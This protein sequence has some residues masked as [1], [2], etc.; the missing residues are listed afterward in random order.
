MET[1]DKIVAPTRTPEI[2]RLD[3]VAKAIGL[4]GVALFESLK[5]AS[6]EARLDDTKAFPNN[7]EVHTEAIKENVAFTD[8]ALMIRL[9][10]AQVEEVI[11]NNSFNPVDLRHSLTPAIDRRKKENH[12]IAN[13]RKSL[14]GIRQNKPG[15]SFNIGRAK[16]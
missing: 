8:N 1:R 6:R 13:G 11:A 15:T 16:I 14:A 12:Q 3:R 4:G 10:T 2:S 7:A 9:Y 5:Q